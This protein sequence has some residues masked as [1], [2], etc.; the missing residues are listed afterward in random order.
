MSEF[1]S[2]AP[3]IRPD[4]EPDVDQQPLGYLTPGGDWDGFADSD[5]AIDY[6]NEEKAIRDY[7][8]GLGVTD[9]GNNFGIRRHVPGSTGIIPPADER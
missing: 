9:G 2:F 6:P 4:E 1:E 3:Y 7:E 8:A 5:F